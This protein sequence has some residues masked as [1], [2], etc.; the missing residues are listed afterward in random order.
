M[1]VYTPVSLYQ[2]L[3][4]NV[5]A[6]IISDVANKTILKEIILCN[7]TGNIVTVDLK[8]LLS[9][10]TVPAGKNIMF[11]GSG[12]TLQAYETKQLTL[13]IV[14]ETGDSLW[15]GSNADASVACQVS[16]VSVTA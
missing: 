10:E 6:E 11:G 12:M 15:A 4:S 5:D 16:G 7:T 13:S 8:K 9:G 14:L 1:A 2:G 3:L